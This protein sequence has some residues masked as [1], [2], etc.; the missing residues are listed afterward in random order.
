MGFSVKT[1]EN[2]YRNT[3]GYSATEAERAAEDINRMA[4]DDSVKAAVET[5][6]NLYPSERESI[7]QQ[8]D[9]LRNGFQ[10]VEDNDCPIK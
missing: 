10:K 7:A 6:S 8:L 4:A 1:G 3:Y 9:S 5:Y 2:F